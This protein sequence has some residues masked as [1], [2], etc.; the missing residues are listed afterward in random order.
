MCV[1]T[2]KEKGVSIGNL[3]NP[4]VACH[5]FLGKLFFPEAVVVAA[6]LTEKNTTRALPVSAFHLMLTLNNL[7]PTLILICTAAAA[8]AA[9]EILINSLCVRRLPP[10]TAAEDANRLT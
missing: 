1:G 10:A 9:A 7:S 2:G 3:C 4:N 6:A 5:C 8:A